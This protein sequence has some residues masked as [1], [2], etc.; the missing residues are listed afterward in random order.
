LYIFKPSGQVL[1][2]LFLAPLAVLWTNSEFNISGMVVNDY[3]QNFQNTLGTN[4]V[5]S[6]SLKI[7]Y[8]IDYNYLKRKR[9]KEIS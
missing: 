9:T 6:I 4:R 3:W 1:R 5:N 2:V 8:Y 7:L